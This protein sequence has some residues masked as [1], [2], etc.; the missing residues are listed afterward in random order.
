[1]VCGE[2]PPAS[3]SRFP[4]VRATAPSDTAVET[5][6]ARTVDLQLEVVVIA[7]ADV[8]RAKRFDGSLGWRLDVDIAAHAE[9]G[10]GAADE[11]GPRAARGDGSC[12]SSMRLNT[13]GL[14]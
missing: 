4:V 3:C 5:S 10:A 8:D 12:T 6:R 9:V 11:P 14:H 7:V 2:G 1:M 13:K